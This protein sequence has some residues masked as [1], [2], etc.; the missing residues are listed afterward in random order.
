M[1]LRPV[2]KHW[3]CIAGAVAIGMTS[4]CATT[5][6]GGSEESFAVR[7][8]RYA[9]AVARPLAA[10]PEV[11]WGELPAVFRELGYQGG[12]S[13]RVGER[14]FLTPS[15]RIRGR[16]YPDAPNAAY[17][18]CGPTPSGA[19]AADEYD[20]SFVVLLRVTGA[21]AGGSLLEV[22]VDGVARRRAE[23]ASSIYCSG[24]GRLERMF[25]DAVEQRVKRSSAG[26]ARQ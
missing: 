3:R 14:V 20:V 7:V 1:I 9:A 8:R 11:V 24:T 12:P 5:P 25:A 16:L 13:G 17:L 23:E 2:L 6:A 18:D 19:P 10:P 4:A 15:M 21:S 26:G 22:V